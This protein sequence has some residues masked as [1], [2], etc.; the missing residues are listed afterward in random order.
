MDACGGTN[1]A[2]LRRA[3]LEPGLSTL[4]GRGRV[5]LGG[6]FNHS[7]IQPP[8]PWVAPPEELNG[9]EQEQKLVAVGDVPVNGM[10]ELWVGA[11]AGPV[12]R[13][14]PAAAWSI[15]G[16]LGSR[17]WSEPGPP[18]RGGSVRLMLPVL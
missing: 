11:A 15:G 6:G 13:T 5:H 18:R 4:P 10:H 17:G 16:G 14:S 12:A 3:L 9:L 7:S 8:P 1:A 2:W